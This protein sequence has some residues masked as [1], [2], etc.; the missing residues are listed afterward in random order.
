LE[1]KELEGVH[2]GENTVEAIDSLL[3][4][5]GLR[6][7]L[8]TITN[9]NASNNETLILELYGIL[10]DQF[11]TIDNPSPSLPIMRFEGLT[12]Y[13]RCIAHVLNLI[14][15]NILKGKLSIFNIHS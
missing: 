13:I 3:K 5:F 7:K 14:V 12:S 8:L 10:L 4:E 9:D 2:S 15:S 11:D 1:F 6:A